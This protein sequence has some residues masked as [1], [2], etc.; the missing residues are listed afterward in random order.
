MKGGGWREV[1]KFDATIY[2]LEILTFS[3]AFLFMVLLFWN[4]NSVH[5][6]KTILF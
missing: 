4:L 1:V 3:G 5:K 2:D 6:F